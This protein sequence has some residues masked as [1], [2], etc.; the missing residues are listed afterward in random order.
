MGTSDT[1]KRGNRFEEKLS[2]LEGSLLGK[3]QKATAKGPGDKIKDESSGGCTASCPSC[4]TFCS[5][6]PFH[7]YKHSCKYCGNDWD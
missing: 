4:L 3:V 1:D 2:N 7:Y 5:K 6:S